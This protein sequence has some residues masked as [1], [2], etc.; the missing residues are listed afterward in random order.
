MVPGDDGAIRT[1]GEAVADAAPTG[2][3][4]FPFPIAER[5]QADHRRHASAGLGDFFGGGEAVGDE[6]LAEE[7]VL[8][9]VAGDGQFGQDDEV[10]R[11]IPGRVDGLG[12][13]TGICPQVTDGGIDLCQ[14]DSHDGR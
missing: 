8:G 6:P 11:L 2:G 14:G 5:G 1:E 4:A 3:A 9:R 10:G 12:D 7:Q 13:E